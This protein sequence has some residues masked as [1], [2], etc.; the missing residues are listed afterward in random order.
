M[1]EWLLDSLQL[2]LLLLLSRTHFHWSYILQDSSESQ[3]DASPI[4]FASFLSPSRSSHSSS[5]HFLLL[6]LFTASRST[7]HCIRHPVAISLFKWF[8]LPFTQSPFSFP[9]I[10][11]H[12]P[13][14]PTQPLPLLCNPCY[15][16][17][18]KVYT[19]THTHT[20]PP[21]T[22]GDLCT[23][24]EYKRRVQ[25]WDT[26]YCTLLTST[27]RMKFTATDLQLSFSLM[28]VCTLFS[29]DCSLLCRWAP[30]V[31]HTSAHLYHLLSLFI[32]NNWWD[33]I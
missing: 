7:S 16:E 23:E 5:L 22:G 18:T 30:P 8:S 14:H 29:V 9:S 12:F 32:R 19:H 10:W 25:V 33:D 3:Q 31:Y 21:R 20:P 28:D 15:T 13:T 4:D 24:K 1:L 6:H 2:L 11:F 26:R 17:Y 27:M